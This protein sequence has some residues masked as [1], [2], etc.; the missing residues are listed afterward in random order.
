M[1][2]A[3]GIQDELSRTEK[4]A[5]RLAQKVSQESQIDKA[6]APIAYLYGRLRTKPEKAALLARVIQG[7]IEGG[8]W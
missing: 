3:W 5:A 7:V 4:D 8:M 1:V 2:Q 6:V